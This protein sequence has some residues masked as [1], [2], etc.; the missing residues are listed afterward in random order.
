[1][2]PESQVGA[3]RDFVFWLEALNE[4]KQWSPDIGCKLFYFFRKESRDRLTGQN[5]SLSSIAY[6]CSLVI[7][8]AWKHNK[9]LLKIPV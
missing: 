3:S 5:K 1:M 2:V 6:D 8:I 4:F 9:D 7:G